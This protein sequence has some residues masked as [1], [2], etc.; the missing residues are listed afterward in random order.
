MELGGNA[1][2]LEFFKK[3]GLK[4][5]YDYRGPIVAKYKQELTK[6]VF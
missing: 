6:K 4:T 1:K 5:P 2:A 3:Q